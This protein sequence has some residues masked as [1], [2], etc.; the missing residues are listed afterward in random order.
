MAL[1]SGNMNVLATAGEDSLIKLWDVRVKSNIGTLKGHRNAVYGVK[2]GIQS[3]ILCSVSKDL[4][5]K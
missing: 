5:L 1:H 2:F 3:N 4:T